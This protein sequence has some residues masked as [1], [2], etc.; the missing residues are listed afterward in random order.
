[1]LNQAFAL[2]RAGRTRIVICSA[3]L[4]DKSKGGYRGRGLDRRRRLPARRGVFLSAVAPCWDARGSRLREQTHGSAQQVY[5]VVASV[6]LS[7]EAR[8]DR[9]RTSPVATSVVRITPQPTPA[10][11]PMMRMR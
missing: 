1:V 6:L 5:L 3:A 11:M 7:L 10:A 2:V 8:E 4:D 9:C